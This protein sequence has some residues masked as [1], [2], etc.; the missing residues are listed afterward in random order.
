MSDDGNVIAVAANGEEESAIF[1]YKQSTSKSGEDVPPDVIFYPS[2]EDIYWELNGLSMDGNGYAAAAIAGSYI[3]ALTSDGDFLWKY[4][5]SGSEFSEYF[6]T[7]TVSSNGRYAVAGSVMPLSVYCFTLYIPPYGRDRWEAIKRVH[8][9]EDEIIDA[10]NDLDELGMSLEE[11]S[12]FISEGGYTYPFTEDG[13]IANVLNGLYEAYMYLR[14]KIITS[15]IPPIP[16]GSELYNELVSEYGLL[17][18]DYP[19]VSGRIQ[20][21]YAILFGS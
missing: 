15:D 1:F 10:L 11:L 3:F 12:D 19:T 8:D 2:S 5:A 21:L 4:Y 14:S 18:E 17:L 6:T 16:V 9:T 7:V 13:D 20:L